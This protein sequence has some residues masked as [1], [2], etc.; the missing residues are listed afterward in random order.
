MTTLE[1]IR[2]E[3][4]SLPP[5]DRL[6]LWRELGNDLRGS[7]TTEPEQVESAWI[8]EI[9]SRVREV[10]SGEASMLSGLEFEQRTRALFAELGIDREPRDFPPA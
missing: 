1:H 4:K 6:S 9:D 8:A 10:H 7:M 3:I 5:S 2:Q